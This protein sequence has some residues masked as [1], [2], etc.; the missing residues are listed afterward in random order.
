MKRFALPF[1]GICLG[2]AIGV[3]AQEPSVAPPE[4][5]V[6][7]GVPK[8]PAS[9]AET[10]GRYGAYR[11]AGLA[12]WHPTERKML[13]STRFAETPQLHLVSVPGGER[14]QL[15]FFTD[16]VRGARFHPN[17][18]D[19]IVFP[20]DIGGGEWY[21]LYR[22]DL[23]TGNITLL[24]DGKSRNSLG[25]WSSKGDQI[26]Y[27]S[28]RRTGKDTDLWVMNPMD[29]KSDHLLTQLEGGG[30]QPLDW[31]PDDKQILLLE[32]LSINESYLWLVNATTG[33]KTALTPR[34]AKEKVSY[35]EGQFSK[36]GMGIFV[37]TDKDSEF[38]RLAYVSLKT[39]EHSYLTS[40]IP[41]DVE[42]FD[43]SHDGKRIAFV[44][45]ENGLSVLRDFNVATKQILHQPKN[46]PSGVIGTV[47]WR[48]NGPELAITIT[49][50]QGPGDVYSLDVV[51]GKLERWTDSETAVP[52]KDFPAAELVKW[53]SFDGKMIS[54]FLYR[55]SA[56]FT[57]KR[58]VLVV[59]HG[60]P[61]GQSQPIFLGRSNYLLNELGIALIYPNVRGS[62]GYGKTFT[63]MDNGFQREGTYKDINALFDWIATQ[64]EL[65]AS[66]IGVTGGSYGGHMTLAISTFYSDRIRCSVDIVGMSNLVTFLEHTEGYRRDLRRVEYGDERDPK[67]REYL[68]RIAPMNNIEKIKKPMLVVAGKNDPRVP[69]TE[70]DQIVAALKKSG[71]PVWYIMAKDEGHGFQKKANQDYQFYATVEFLQEYL[72]K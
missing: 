33:G 48:R 65:D 20:K 37:T 40:K 34:D 61:E 60:G 6:V 70:S 35:G 19:Y 69:V 42:T 31:S 28:T 49:N 4:S 38:H 72:L 71:T 36:D 52:T 15:T 57:G 3:A 9:L 14:H 55:P 44:T 27:T 56:K 53:K 26:A 67:M 5:L 50:A 17:G 46:L 29:P 16:A 41:W 32:E 43:L 66:R 45:D 68:E 13:I 24:T 2:C 30:W 58:P 1:A 25:P 23:A 62:T 10:A 12:D 21:Q 11:N 22:L 39:K 18:G 47:R 8:I 63:L 59:I 54:G 51:T 64:P 7:E